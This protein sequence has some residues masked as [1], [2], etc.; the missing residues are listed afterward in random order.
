[1]SNAKAVLRKE[2]QHLAEEAFHHKLI[3]GYGDGPDTNEYQI[4]FQGKPR[5]FALEE[6]R[7]F[8][9]ELLFETQVDQHSEELSI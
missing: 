1:M 7:S 4:V 2:V 3:S 6:A 9:C 8:L 5:H